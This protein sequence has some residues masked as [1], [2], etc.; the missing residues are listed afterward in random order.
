MASDRPNKK[1]L[2]QGNLVFGKQCVGTLAI[3]GNRDIFGIPNKILGI[4]IQKRGM[5]G[6]K[7]VEFEETQNNGG[8][9]SSGTARD[10]ESWWRQGKQI[11]IDTIGVTGRTY[12][13]LYQAPL[14]DSMELA[15]RVDSIGLGEHYE[16]PE[17]DL[18]NF[19]TI[20]EI[21]DNDPTDLGAACPPVLATE[22]QARTISK[23]QGR[24]SL[25]QIADNYS[26]E[27]EGTPEGRP[28]SD[29]KQPVVHEGNL[30]IKEDPDCIIDS[31][32]LELNLI[33]T[34]CA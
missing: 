24:P 15:Q 21:E 12:K 1:C 10:C 2:L 30:P 23:S 18:D 20:E 32:H 7:Y 19:V 13:P 33:V 28:T 5:S 8:N 9:G 16:I 4:I 26:S 27:E 6:W 3:K 11:V 22:R 31:V 25:Q 17:S 14:D 34:H 29:S